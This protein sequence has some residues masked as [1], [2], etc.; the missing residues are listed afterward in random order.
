[1][2]LSRGFSDEQQDT[3]ERDAE[4]DHKCSSGGPSSGLSPHGT[5]VSSF[6]VTGAQADF[7]SSY[8]SNS[9]CNVCF[10][11]LSRNDETFN[12]HG[13]F[14]EQVLDVVEFGRRFALGV[15]AKW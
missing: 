8:D 6:A 10:E 7:S 3:A 1:M 14:K 11:A 12:T 9:H 4:R 15:Y 2:S 5:S 13:R